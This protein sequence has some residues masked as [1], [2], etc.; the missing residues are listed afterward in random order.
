[1]LGSQTEPSQA[2]S[3]DASMTYPRPLAVS[4]DAVF[5]REVDVAIVG[6]GIIGCSAAL[7]LAE[8]GLRVA[9]FEKGRIAAEQSCRNWGFCRISGRDMREIPLA[10]ESL[11]IWDGL[12]AKVGRDLGFR[13]Y[14][15]LKIAADRRQ[16]DAYASWAQRAEAYGVKARM[17]EAAELRTHLDGRARRDFAGALYTPE[18]GRA[19][20]QL[21]APS[22]AKAARATGLVSLHQDCAVRVIETEAG[23]IG[24]VVTER[25]EVKCRAVLV[26]GGIWSRLFLKPYGIRF[27]QL[28][29]R[30][31]AMRV[32]PADQEALPRETFFC[33]DFAFRRHL[34]GSMTI[35]RGISVLADLLPDSFVFLRDF[36]PALMQEASTLRP[37]FG[38]RFFEVLSSHKTPRADRESVFERVRIFAPEP[39]RPYNA[40]ALASAAA[41]F[42]GIGAAKPLLE[43]AGYIDATPDAVPAISPVEAMPGLYL[44]SGF[45]GHGFGIG[46][47]AGYA[48]AALIAGRTPA[49]ALDPF[50]F[51]RFTGGQRLHPEVGI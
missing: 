22:I 20:P 5:P 17:M 44:A 50:S 2:L 41:A 51:N 12:A 34:D 19:E 10:A 32:M 37:R 9:L 42:P 48:A 25:G 26:A 8:Q 27:P 43:W 4:S 23:R 28:P 24:S 1:M 15:Q 39:H 33:R 40:E 36:L 14:G 30:A 13:R 7:A 29:V 18:D 38:R 47:G 21:A 46:P 16:F 45:S 3:V 35:A 49:V 11:R 31:T 6:G